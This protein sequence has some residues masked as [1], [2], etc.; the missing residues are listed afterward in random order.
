M[1]VLHIDWWFQSDL[2]GLALQWQQADCCWS[3]VMAHRVYWVHALS[4]ICLKVFHNKRLE[5]K[6]KDRLYNPSHLTALCP[7]DLLQPVIP[8]VWNVLHLIPAYQSCWTIKES[9]RGTSFM[10]LTLLPVPGCHSPST[11]SSEHLLWQLCLDTYGYICLISSPRL[12]VT[13]N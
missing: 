1:T 13:E 9:P 6:K 2:L 12:W 5:G 7:K 3:R 11:T 4:G 8:C 10:K